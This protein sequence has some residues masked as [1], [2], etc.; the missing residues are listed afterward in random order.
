MELGG[1]I[2]VESADFACEKRSLFV[3]IAGEAAASDDAVTFGW[4]VE[5]I[6]NNSVQRLKGFLHTDCG[7]RKR[8]RRTT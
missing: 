3:R 6:V 5:S 1:G 2:V 7:E 4:I 8:R